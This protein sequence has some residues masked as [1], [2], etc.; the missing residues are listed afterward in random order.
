MWILHRLI[1]WKNLSAV[2]DWK[3]EKLEDCK[4]SREYYTLFINKLKT[5]LY[6]HAYIHRIM[7]INYEIEHNK[8]VIRFDD[9]LGCEIQCD[10]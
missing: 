6:V 8:I 7:R 10:L 2:A 5:F 4:I 9:Y 1:D 3:I